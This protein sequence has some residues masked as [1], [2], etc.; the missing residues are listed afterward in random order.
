[1]NAGSSPPASARECRTAVESASTAG[2]S[3]HRGHPFYRLLDRFATRTRTIAAQ[4]RYLV[5]VIVLVAPGD[6]QAQFSH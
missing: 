4:A 3:R 5:P 6:R 2:H 1:M